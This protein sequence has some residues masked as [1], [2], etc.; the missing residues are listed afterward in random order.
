MRATIQSQETFDEYIRRIESLGIQDKFT[1]EYFIWHDKNFNSN[2]YE[3]LKN[4]IG[5]VLPINSRVQHIIHNQKG[6]SFNVTYRLNQFGQRQTILRGNRSQHLILAGDSNTFGQGVEDNW[7]LDSL[8]FKKFS[9]YNTYNFGQLGGGPSN[10]LALLETTSWF[11]QIKEN[12]GKMIYIFYPEWMTMRVIGSKQYITLLG[13]QTPYFFLDSDKKLVRKGNLGDRLISKIFLL[14]SKLD[15]F[16]LIGDL[17]P[18]TEDHI[19]LIAKIFN[20]MQLE[21][22]KMF[23]SGE[24][25]VAIIARMDVKHLFISELEKKLSSEGVK[26]ATI[27]INSQPDPPQKYLFDHHQSAI[28][29]QITMDSLVKAISF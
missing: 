25:A 16:H 7:T 3:Q 13:G 5:R 11:E 2:E 24:F 8:F 18:L 12:K 17:P 9:N 1:V 26:F 23:P 20:K 21:Y 22:K 27:D 29:Q 10:T 14:I 19:E 28:G 4:K 15:Y 6:D